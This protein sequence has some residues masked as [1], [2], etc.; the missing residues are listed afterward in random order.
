MLRLRS[1]ITSCATIVSCNVCFPVVRTAR[2]VREPD[3][4][5]RTSVVTDG[6]RARRAALFSEFDRRVRRAHGHVCSMFSQA[7]VRRFIASAKAA[8][9]VALLILPC[10]FASTARA[11]LWA[12]VDAQGRSH[13]ANHQVD[14]RYTLFFKGPTTLDVP[15]AA[16][17]ERASALAALSGTR[18]YQR[19]MDERIVRRY[20]SLIETHARTNGLDPAFVKAVIA[21][22]SAFDPLAVSTKGAIGLMQVIPETA[23][24]YGLTSDARLSI[25]DK[26]RDP[27]TNVRIGTRYLRDLL[28]RYE[29]DMML[30]LAAYNAGEGA[31]AHHDNAIPPFA[32]TR[33]YVMRVRQVYS[34]YREPSPNARETAVRLIRNAPA[35]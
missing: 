28:A 1:I 3:K 12:Y 11:D 30:A 16:T 13:L 4:A 15:D 18:L 19:A 35:G 29:N 21:V 7:A 32:E 14:S 31:V 10:A 20:A 5:P 27:T 33:G 25:A 23:A 22:E 17:D 26:L 8:R 34:L 9:L 6:T 2:A 24:R